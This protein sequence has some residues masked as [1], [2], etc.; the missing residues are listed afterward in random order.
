MNYF[1][2]FVLLPLK[3]ADFSA[4][5]TIIIKAAVVDEING[6]FNFKTL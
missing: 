4:T 3:L 2:H 5:E 6:E 1:I